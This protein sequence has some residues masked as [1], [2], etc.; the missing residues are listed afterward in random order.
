MQRYP[1]VS[2]LTPTCNRRPFIA[3]Y[4]RCVRRQDYA[5]PLE[6]L[7]A[8]DGTDPI[9]DLLGSDERI[10]YLRLTQRTPLGAKRNLLATEARGSVL[11][12]MDD[13]D[14]YPPDRVSHA[15]KRLQGSDA[16]LAGCSELHL[17]HLDTGELSVSGPFGANHATAATLAYAREYLE[18]HQF[19][20]AASAQ[21]EP[22][23]TANFTSPMVQL[24]PRSTIMVVSHSRNT[25]DK[26]RTRAAPSPLRLKDF[27][28]DPEDRR[29]YRRRLA[30]SLEAD[31]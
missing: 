28:R 8:D 24:D 21:E 20:A 18:Q 31:R 26:S 16:R 22:S 12:H 2:I 25:W 15:V 19:D 30:Q 13:D 3:Q 6:I 14:Y 11:V 27:V 23:F 1:L 17:Y 7:V 5:G 10:R 4:L 9:G 29:F